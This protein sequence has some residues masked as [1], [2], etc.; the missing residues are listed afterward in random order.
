MRILLV[1][2]LSISSGLAHAETPAEIATKL[3]D[4]QLD[5]FKTADDDKFGRQFAP[6]ALF[7]VSGN[8]IVQAE[9]VRVTVGLTGD[10]RGEITGSKKLSL[11]AGGNATVVWFSG[12]VEILFQARVSPGEPTKYKTAV[13]F[14]ELAVVDGGGKWHVV[15]AE[16]GNP[17]SPS[18][19][20]GATI[21]QGTKPGTLAKLVIDPKQLAFQLPAKDDTVVVFGTDARERA[22]G[23]PAAKKLLE[24]WKTL[25]LELAGG[26]RE[27]T[28]A[29][30]GFVQASL[31]WTKPD[32]K[33][34]WMRVLVIATRERSQPWVI[35]AVH[36]G[37]P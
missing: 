13:R 32:G 1:V 18:D 24:S 36:Y 26:V 27:V 4:A 14:T 34:L 15:A 35:R 21:P 2:A 8:G 23:V 5:A 12:E 16:W 10:G 22:V 19:G 29:N 28:T 6:D 9:R 31:K 3:I 30:Y 37:L 17:T 11:T 33:P 20:D 25:K 7:G